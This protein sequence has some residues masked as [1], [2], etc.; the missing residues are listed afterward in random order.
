MTEEFKAKVTAQKGLYTFN[1]VED[2][3]TMLKV[4]INSVTI[5]TRATIGVVNK[6]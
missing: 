4:L 5:E 3:L 6:K 1:G 2:G